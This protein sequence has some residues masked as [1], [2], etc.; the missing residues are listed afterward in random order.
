MGSS[1]SKTVRVIIMCTL[2][3]AACSSGR[4]S[5]GGSAMTGTAATV[6]G[7]VASPAAGAIAGAGQSA[8]TLPADPQIAPAQPGTPGDLSASELIA[9]LKASGLPVTSSIVYTAAT[10][11]DHL[12]GQ[13]S[14]YI[15]KA[16][17]VDSRVPRDGLPDTNPGSVWLGGCVEVFRTPADAQQRQRFLMSQAVDPA[18]AEYL[19]VRGPVLLRVSHELDVSYA[20][21]YGKIL[22]RTG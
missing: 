12:F 15:S 5:G 1:V 8:P 10:D 17:F 13:S 7:T 4:A 6:A 20:D 9:Q 22:Q 16:A 2:L 3:V 14:G 19:Y 18:K 21:G 11:S